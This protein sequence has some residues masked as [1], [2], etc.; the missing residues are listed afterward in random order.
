M[1]AV[2]PQTPRAPNANASTIVGDRGRHVN[3]GL[4]E[5]MKAA[6]MPS[7]LVAQTD[8]ERTDGGSPLEAIRSPK[9]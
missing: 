8:V 5:Q 7:G 1:A 4:E 3:R 2:S 9:K 6:A